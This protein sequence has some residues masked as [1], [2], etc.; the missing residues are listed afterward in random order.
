MYTPQYSDRPAR[1][2]IFAPRSNSMAEVGVC[3]VQ[4]APDTVYCAMLLT[5]GLAVSVIQME[6]DEDHTNPYGR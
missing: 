6:L 4:V 2:M 3:R 5:V 1:E